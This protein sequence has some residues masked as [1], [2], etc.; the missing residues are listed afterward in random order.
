M[1]EKFKRLFVETK[2][3]TENWFK[4]GLTQSDLYELQNDLL[5]DP[6]IGDVIQQTGGVRKLRYILKDK[7]KRGG[8]RVIYV[9]I[10]IA[11]TIFLLDV[12]PKSRKV[13]LSQS[14]K[15]RIKQLVEQL[16]EASKP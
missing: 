1:N 10:E 16:K 8:C 15:R 4:L 11:E 5:D 13:D 2:T 6:K 3:F 12:Y 9:D 14:E 7:G